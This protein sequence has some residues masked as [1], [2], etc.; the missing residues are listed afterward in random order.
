MNCFEND[1]RPLW[2]T[3][4]GMTLFKVPW[5]MLGYIPLVLTLHSPAKYTNFT[6]HFLSQ[7]ESTSKQP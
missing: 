2:M 4:H 7:S 6:Y 3:S 1:E 5:E